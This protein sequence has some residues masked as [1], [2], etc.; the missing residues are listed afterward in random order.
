MT[1]N[2]FCF[3]YL[4]TQ[5]SVQLC[6][7]SSPRLFDPVM[8][9]L[10]S[11]HPVNVLVLFDLDSV[12]QEHTLDFVF[13]FAPNLAWTATHVYTGPVLCTNL[14]RFPNTLTKS[15]FCFSW[16]IWRIF[17]KLWI[18]GHDKIIH[19]PFP[20]CLCE[21]LWCEYRAI[22]YFVRFVHII[23]R[24]GCEMKTLYLFFFVPC[25][26]PS[27][28]FSSFWFKMLL[29]LL[30]CVYNHFIHFYSLL[31]AN[32]LPRSIGMFFHVYQ[33]SRNLVGYFLL[34]SPRFPV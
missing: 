32:F 21:S 27:L 12:S 22:L 2:P 25:L 18:L 10:V 3:V 29:F 34:I 8:H 5:S 33:K 16:K 11:Y 20:P 9:F 30:D 24:H 4:Y 13:L 28:C 23:D 26:K 14:S 7:L 1:A 15:T 17:G 6:S 31:V 19:P